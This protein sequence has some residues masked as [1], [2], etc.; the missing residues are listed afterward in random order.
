MPR[1][2]RVQ[3]DGAVYF[4][5]LEGPYDEKIFKDHDD[6]QKYLELLT[7]CKQE[8]HFKLFSY[9]LLPT[10]LFLLIEANDEFSIS[11][12]MQRVTPL[13]TKYFNYRHE[14]KGPLFQKRFRSVIAEKEVNLLALTRYIH[15]LPQR[16]HLVENFRDY[17]YTSQ[18][19]F[20]KQ[21][22]A[23]GIEHPM[24]LH[25]EVE[26]ILGL[27]PNPGLDDAYE[28]Y[29]LSGSEKE[30]EF[31]DKKLSRGFILGS[32]LF[33]SEVRKRLEEESHPEEA[34]AQDSDSGQVVE[35]V[36]AAAVPAPA[37]SFDKRTFALSGAL[38]A[39]VLVS[40]FSAYLNYSTG[41]P[42]PAGRVVPAVK[43]AAKDQA[44]APV[45]QDFSFARPEHKVDLNGTIWEIELIYV[46]PDGVSH[47]INDRIKFT[48]K[49]FQ[50]HYFSSQGF[51]HSNY[52]VSVNKN[53]VITWETI[54]RNEKGETISWHGDWTGKKMEGNLS[55][56]ASGEPGPKD[57]SFMS[58]GG[59]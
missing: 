4:V 40:G 50:S 46:S 19:A 32:E 47:P 5:T 31:L 51:S 28:R 23:S 36:A 25:E 55:Y 57:F 34:P 16:A 3:L 38:L 21:A 48:G 39:A 54:Q 42:A 1:P 33:T 8:Y 26:E 56:R 53:G 20:L 6:Y 49:A 52:T 12:I 11:K 13:Y 18:F 27:L 44:P 35:A 9:A 59:V 17:S 14:R 15:L 41:R 29:L 58:K 45:I 43:A 10:Q 37:P 2:P 7:Q 24:D 30:L 22:D